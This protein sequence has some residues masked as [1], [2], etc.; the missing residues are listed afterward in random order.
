M[1]V[2]L[3]NHPLTEYG[4]FDSKRNE[5]VSI[6]YLAHYIRKYEY[7]CDIYDPTFNSLADEL[8]FYS[9]IA[10]NYDVVGF[11][12][13]FPFNPIPI[14]TRIKK[15]N[16]NI[17]TILGGPHATLCF[18]EFIND[19]NVDYV[20]LGEGEKRL[21][22]LLDVLS[23]REVA[24]FMPGIVSKNQSIFDLEYCDSQKELYEGYP[25]RGKKDFN[26]YIPTVISSRGCNSKCTFCSNQYMG[27][28]RGRGVLDVI[29]EIEYLVKDMGQSYFQF[30]EPNFLHDVQR[31]E[32]IAR[33]LLKRNISVSFDFAARVDS[34]NKGYE[35]I[36]ILKQ[37]GAT[38]ILLG[39]ENFSDEI[40][41]EWKKGIRL[42]DIKKSIE[43][44]NSI[45]MAFTISL[46]LFHEKLDLPELKFNLKMIEE[47]S[48]SECIDK[49]FNKLIYYPGTLL[50]PSKEIKQWNFIDSAISNIYD[51]CEAYESGK[52][53]IY[54]RLS[55]G[56]DRF[57]TY[58]EV[59]EF[60]IQNI[61]WFNNT[62]AK[63]YF[64]LK[65]IT[66]EIN[67]ESADNEN[68]FSE[69]NERFSTSEN[70]QKI[71]F[72]KSSKIDFLETESGY[73]TLRNYDMG[74]D[75]L[76]ND[77]AAFIYIETLN[78]SLN[79]VFLALRNKILINS[80]EM[81]YD[82]LSVIFT[83]QKHHMLYATY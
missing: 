7:E 61:H 76:L 52:K 2:A 26:L 12:I 42:A 62:K 68:I 6:Q 39:V 32:D 17:V 71:I 59:E 28:W 75:F 72:S 14:L 46:I 43:F 58:E 74:L 18:K 23:D 51:K 27:R 38:R 69:F 41:K 8:S 49:L 29:S 19:N 80:P 4:V 44:L 48:L 81:Y 82:L 9:F 53:R 35:A 34:L 1:K 47:L 45:N 37:A 31:S 57:A 67:D 60:I 21:K 83:F 5:P 25:L 64:F 16:Q 65:Y 70:P 54:A 22:H 55:N 20:I 3:I 77:M 11:S 10:N 56:S 40:L 63:D 36:K 78:K 24:D 50:N 66:N 33:E 73:N 30:V 79:D 13:F 15:I